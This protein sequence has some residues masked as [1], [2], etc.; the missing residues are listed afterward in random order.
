MYLPYLY[1][2]FVADK[3]DEEP[4]HVFLVLEDL[5]TVS[6]NTNLLLLLAD[7]PFDLFLC[8]KFLALS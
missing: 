8:Q 2:T 3:N 7:T 4:L 6:R 1:D 5:C